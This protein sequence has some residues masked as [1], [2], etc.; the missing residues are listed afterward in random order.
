MSPGDVTWILI[1]SA[2]V[3]FMVPGLALFYGGMVRSKNVLN[4]LLMNVYCMGIVPI[5]WVLLAYSLTAGEGPEAGIIGTLDFIGFKDVNDPETIL[6]AFF[7]MT[8]AI[9]T[10]ALIAGAVADRMKFAAWA[11]FVP[12]WVLL[13]YVPVF[14]WIY[15][16]NGWLDER[17]SLDFAG[18]TAIHVN[19]GIAALAMVI[20]L[21]KR[22]GWP[23]EGM[24]PHNL[25]LVMIGAGILWFG[26]FGFNAGSAG[27][28]DAA[29]IQAF[30]N[31]LLAG[32]AA[33]IAWL[34]VEWIKDGHPTTLGAASGIVAGLVAITPA[35]GYVGGL[36]ALAFGAIAGVLCFFAIGLKY[37]LGYDDSL[38]VVGVH[39]VGGI[40][41]GVLIGFFADPNAIPGSDFAAGLFFGGGGELLFEQVLSIV[42]VMAFSFVVTFVLAK[43]LDATIGLRVSDEAE[44]QG[45]DLTEHAE[46]GYAI[47]DLGS[48][49]RV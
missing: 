35:A 49:G 10:P 33:M 36:A 26:W 14:Y 40:I 25:P 48:M 15:G 4:M 44:R 23:K 45:L 8:F 1:S 5:V 16:P 12:V 41:G 6:F 31:T 7:A 32:A 42:V 22:A 2:L 27:A 28:A 37:K 30:M 39:L 17:G 38:D 20:V 43:L 29:A 24:A 46:T 18:G 9:I 13:V 47:G 3:L 19:A 21:G 11:I 34:A